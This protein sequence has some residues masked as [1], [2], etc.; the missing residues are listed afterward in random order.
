MN[1]KTTIS[2]HPVNNGNIF[3]GINMLPGEASTVP[4]VRGAIDR[5]NQRLIDS[6]H[7]P[8]Q[9]QIIRSMTTVIRD[10][11]DN[12]VA[13]TVFDSIVETY[14]ATLDIKHY[15]R[16][17]YYD[18]KQSSYHCQYYSGS[19]DKLKAITMCEYHPGTYVQDAITGKVIFENPKE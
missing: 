8:N 12:L 2:F 1:T 6:D 5:D 16:V 15:Y 7:L 10:D 11:N 19:Y 13:R 9:Y 18:P 3:S 14:P 4:G 17:V